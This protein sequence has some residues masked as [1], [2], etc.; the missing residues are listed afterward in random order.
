MNVYINIECACLHVKAGNWSLETILLNSN[1]LC[2]ENIA[3]HN[4]RRVAVWQRLH[5]LTATRLSLCF[6]IFSGVHK[7]ALNPH[8][9]WNVTNIL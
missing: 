6:A 2:S 3:K 1:V 5:I 9:V 7:F 8:A 4:D